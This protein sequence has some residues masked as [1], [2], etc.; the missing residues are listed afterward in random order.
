MCVYEVHSYYHPREDGEVDI[1]M[2]VYEV[3]SYY[4]PR[5]DGGLDI[6]ICVFMRSRA[7]TTPER[8]KG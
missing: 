5:E 1:Y 2:C 7:T 4:H 8:K 6:Y 3:H